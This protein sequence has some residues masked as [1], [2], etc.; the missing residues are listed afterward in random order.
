MNTQPH[1]L[2]LEIQ[3]GHGSGP[4]VGHNKER[5]NQAFTAPGA[6]RVGH[7]DNGKSTQFP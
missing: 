6:W 4:S 2:G 3:V 7:D 5:R 1:C